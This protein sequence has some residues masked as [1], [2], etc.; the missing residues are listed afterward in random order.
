MRVTEASPGDEE[1]AGGDD[2][3]TACAI[4]PGPASTRST[5]R[6]ASPPT[7]TLNA[8][9]S[10]STG[11]PRERTPRPVPRAAAAAAARSVLRSRHSPERSIACSLCFYDYRCSQQTNTTT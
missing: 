6:A 11:T 5:L 7:H 3:A 8:T 10:T 9:T 2:A 1:D 4:A